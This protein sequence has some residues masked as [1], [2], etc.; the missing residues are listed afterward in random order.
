[1]ALRRNP[2]YM[3]GNNDRYNDDNRCFLQAF[4]DAVS[5]GREDWSRQFRQNRKNQGKDENAVRAAELFGSHP[6][7][8]RT[9][10]LIHESL[11]PYCR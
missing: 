7:I 11:Y 6:G 3:P 8:S 5:E 4:G 10:E 2:D 9:N 1:M